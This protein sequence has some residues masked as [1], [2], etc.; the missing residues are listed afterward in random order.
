MHA[1]RPLHWYTNIFEVGDA[2]N[3]PG[4]TLMFSQGGTQGGEG[5]TGGDSWY[6]ENVEEEL[7]MGREWFFDQATST[8][9]YMPSTTSARPALLRSWAN[10]QAPSQT[11]MRSHSAC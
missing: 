6:I 8:L 4:P 1:W 9:L 5:V 2:A 7:D 3:H 11:R 10:F